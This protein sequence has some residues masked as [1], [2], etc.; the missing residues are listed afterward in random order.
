[1]KK[2][3]FEYAQITQVIPISLN[4]IL[5]NDIKISVMFIQY[6]HLVKINQIYCLDRL[7][8]N[9]I[10]GIFQKETYY[11]FQS[12]IMILTAKTVTFYLL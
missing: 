7:H 12:N 8:S 2:M 6:H 10:Y 3:G 4:V 1:M 9:G 5:G 11:H